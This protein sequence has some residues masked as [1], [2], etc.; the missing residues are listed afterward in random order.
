MQRWSSWPL[1]CLCPWQSPVGCTSVEFGHFLQLRHACILGSDK[2]PRGPMGFVL[3]QFCRVGM[4]RASLHRAVAHRCRRSPRTCRRIRSRGIESDSP[5][6]FL[7]KLPGECS[8][9]QGSWQLIPN[10]F[11]DRSS[12][13]L[14]VHHDRSVFWAIPL[15]P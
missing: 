15:A 11:C 1:H 12:K 4:Y 7:S 13:Y 14:H 5:L 6:R 3:S 9:Q 2:W 10:S 8:L